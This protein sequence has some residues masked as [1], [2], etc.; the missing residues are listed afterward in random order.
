M[1]EVPLAAA[2]LLVEGA[3]SAAG[4]RRSGQRFSDVHLARLLGLRR[5]L[6]VLV[7]FLFGLR[8]LLP[9]VVVLLLLAVL[10]G[11][12]GAGCSTPDFQFWRLADSEESGGAGPLLAPFV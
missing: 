11:S 7:D 3:P 2:V 8:V 12:G 9:V 10:L 1:V 6:L 4:L 5:R